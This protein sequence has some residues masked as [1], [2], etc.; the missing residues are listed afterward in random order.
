[1]RFN[2]KLDIQQARKELQNDQKEVNKGAAR[3]L[4][5]VAITGR[6]VADQSIRERA[7]LKSGVVK[8]ALDVRIPYGSRTLIRDIV[9]TGTPIPIRDWNARR[10]KKGVTF[11]VVKGKRKPYVRGGR[12]GFVVDK[13]GKHVFV[14]VTE[15]PPGPQKAKIAKAWGPGITHRFRTRHVQ[16]AIDRTC[17][18]RWPIEFDREMAFRKSKISA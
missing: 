10:T 8:N 11:A 16:E 17:R 13:L 15:D 4:Q 3:A 9:A 5:R 1:M 14:R 2:V 12:P 18:Q 7:L 6:K